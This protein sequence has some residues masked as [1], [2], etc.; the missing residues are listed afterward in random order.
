[1][2][3]IYVDALRL[4]PEG[5]QALQ[6][7]NGGGILISPK[8]FA[9]GSYSGPE[10][11]QV[12]SE[13][14]GQELAKGPLAIIQVITKNSARFVFDV[15]LDYKNDQNIKYIGEIL[16]KL[17]DGLPFGHV[18]LKEPLAVP[19][20][21][22]LR[23]SLLIHTQYDVQ[24][25]LDVTMSE[26]ATVPSVAHIEG[27]PARDDN[28][29]NSVSVLNMHDNSDGTQS[30]GL[31]YRYGPGGYFWG[32]SEHD[33]VFSGP[34][35]ASYISQNLFNYPELGFENGEYIIVQV[36][37]GP[38][39]GPCR[40]FKHESGQLINQNSPIPFI[41][42]ASEIAIWRRIINPLE[43]VTFVPIPE[44]DEVPPD[45]VL[46]KGEDDKP[47]W[48]PPA[49]ANK[50]LGG[51]MF[52][53]PGKLVITNVVT[54]ATPDKVSYELPD[55]VFSA[56][57]LML[58]TS[59]LLQP[60][61]A[62]AVHGRNVVLS[63]PVPEPMSLM[64]RTFRSEPSQ[65]H[66]LLFNLKEYTGDGQ[67][68][69]FDLGEEVSS[70]DNIIA[71]VGRLWQPTTAYQ[72]KENTKIV[73]TEPL[74][75]GT[76]VSLYIARY[77]ERAGWS[78][79]IRV[80][81]YYTDYPQKEFL[82]PTI[83]LSKSH[84]IVTEN[85]VTIHPQDFTVV[86]DI[87]VTTSNIDPDRIIEIMVFENV[88]AVGSKDTALEGMIIDAC[89]TP[90]G[91]EL[92]RQGQKPIRIPMPKPFL[93]ASNGITIKG[94]WPNL[95]F[96]LT[97][98]L[99]DKTDSKK[100]YNLSERVD[101]SEEIQIIQRVD[102]VKGV[103]LELHASFSAELGPGF[104]ESSGL[105]H[106]EYVLSIRSP[107]TKEAEYARGVKGS[108]NAG[109]SVVGN[110]SLVIA[111]SNANMTQMYELLRQNHKAGYVEVVAKM[112]VVGATVSA[113]GSSL[114]THLSIKVDPM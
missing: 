31:A 87:L 52:V 45:W 89:P 88:L 62:F 95:M 93:R 17:E 51:T 53:P 42:A 27:L 61:S 66:A 56:S 16:I 21:F 90:N 35:G 84:V 10:P 29:L 78:S 54:T 65:G 104:A 22:N 30:P 20:N 86:N 67:T 26:Y 48:I 97:S 76:N 57:H 83:P 36:L 111:Y 100:I 46:S 63:E 41:D 105:E 109:F 12:P 44:N 68:A 19:P 34:L 107:G 18:V 72:I 91:V 13:L 28:T 110:N 112:R 6:N 14:I 8:T 101:G 4:H 49:S 50:T 32:F 81:Q 58:G 102:L 15:K 43:P 7:A 106:I 60:R 69:E 98:E 59:G 85:G 71:I 108:G 33:R 113:Y 38:G 9:V 92:R 79:N 64:M 73:F 23:I 47:V 2:S 75:S 96:A 103:I 70:G 3:S 99:E 39:A 25:I 24:A 82:L 5:E 11:A 114:S 77:E 94:V 40:K 74:D 37:S 80:V 1:M 55:E